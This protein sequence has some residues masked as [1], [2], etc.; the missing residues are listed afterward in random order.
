MTKTF[1]DKSGREMLAE[2]IKWASVRDAATG[3]P[4]T[5]SF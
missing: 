4:P 5:F 3:Y 2:L 1:Y